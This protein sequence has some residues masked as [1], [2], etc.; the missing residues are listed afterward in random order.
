MIVNVH[1]YALVYQKTDKFKFEGEERSI[2]G[3]KNPDND[4]R[5][6]WRESNIKSTTKSKDEAFTIINPDT[7]QE[8]TNTWAFSKE[9]LLRMIEENRILWKKTLPKQK[10]FYNEMTNENKAIKSSWGV[11]D[12][13]S[14]TVYLKKYFLKFI[15]IIP[16]L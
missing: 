11:F 12:P 1:E 9:S 3:F 16:N 7:G 13:Q 15:L 6:L 10:E 2:K 8:Y 5:G 14:T 4:P